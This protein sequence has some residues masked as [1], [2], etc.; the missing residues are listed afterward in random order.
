MSYIVRTLPKTLIAERG[1]LGSCSTFPIAIFAKFTSNRASGYFASCQY[2]MV[3]QIEMDTPQAYSLMHRTLSTWSNYFWIGARELFLICICLV[4][5]RIREKILK[6][7]L[8]WCK[9]LWRFGSGD[10]WPMS[11]PEPLVTSGIG[12]T[13]RNPPHLRS[14]EPGES[15]A[16]NS[17]ETNR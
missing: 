6:L 1:K 14:L 7:T 5:A 4:F 2:Y 3:V 10:L 11:G 17:K 15:S 13:R 16:E 12:R 8:L 9:L